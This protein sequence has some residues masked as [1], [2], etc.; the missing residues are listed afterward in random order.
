MGW[1][2]LCG[3]IGVPSAQAG[4]GGTVDSVQRDAQAMSG[5]V[6]RSQ[7]PGLY[8]VHEITTPFGTVVREYVSAAGSVFGVAWEGPVLPDLEPL[9]GT[10]FS[11]LSAALHATRTGHVGRH[12]LSL[13]DDDLV[14]ETRGHSLAHAGRAFIPSLVPAG[15][16]SDVVQ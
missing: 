13:Q 4:L 8:S 9:M 5:R 11:Q 15:V 7:K 6:Q 16:S 10:R 1:L 12:P 3:G 2:L 14:V